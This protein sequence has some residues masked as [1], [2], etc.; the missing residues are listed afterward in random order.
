MST[1]LNIPE[2]PTATNTPAPPSIN[3]LDIYY[4]NGKGFVVGND[5]EYIAITNSELKIHLRTLGFSGARAL[6]ISQLDRA[7][8]DIQFTKCV[9]YVG[10]L[11]GKK[12]GLH[13][14][15]GR[16]VLVTGAP[17]I[18][19]PDASCPW[20]LLKELVE[21]MIGASDRNQLPYFFG[22]LK[23]A[24]STLAAGHPSQGQ[25]LALAGP[26]DCGKSLWQQIIR[27]VL[28]GREANPYAYMTGRTDFNRDL[29]A[30]EVLSFGD[31]VAST[32]YRNRVKFGGLIKQFVVNT[33]QRCHG[34]GRE[35]VVLEPFWRVVM[36]LN[37]EAT[38]LDVLPPLSNDSL[39]DKIMLLR[40]RR[41]ALFDG[42]V[43]Q[44]RTRPE[45]WA[46]IMQELPGFIGFLTEFQIPRELRDTRLGIKAY[47]NPDLMALIGAESPE[48]RLL[49]LIDT[50]RLYIKET[51]RH[52]GAES[53]FVIIRWRGTA[54]ELEARLQEHYATKYFASKLLYYTSACGHLLG[55]LARDH[56]N[57]VK[58]ITSRDGLNRYELYPPEGVE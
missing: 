30:A 20:P 49:E 12:P 6:P 34:K 48:R 58:Q 36:S 7:V 38:S 53:G 4:E 2:I 1:S 15:C 19:E 46:Q 52:E 54:A 56:P 43:W 3:D 50:G 57:R 5:N 28:G 17:R 37:D 11:A 21:E 25:A 40:T 23:H 24:Y 45:N 51:V 32:D 14:I 8:H 27:E 29:F 41:P 13:T 31:E 47:Q 55:A 16:R 44:S 39:T 33:S 9:A 22:W 26:R 35:A 42:P 18:I 10:P